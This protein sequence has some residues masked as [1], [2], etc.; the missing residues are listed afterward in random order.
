[1][2][3][4][5]HIL[6]QTLNAFVTPSPP[7]ILHLSLLLLNWRFNNLLHRVTL[8]LNKTEYEKHLAQFLDHSDTRLNNEKAPWLSPFSFSPLGSV[9]SPTF[10]IRE[11]WKMRL[12]PAQG[13]KDLKM[14]PDVV[15]RDLPLR[16]HRELRRKC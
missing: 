8:E 7:Q 10:Q 6:G 11:S 16:R 14:S 5:S 15:A 2:T 9:K 12:G 4:L 1:M 3:D 13:V